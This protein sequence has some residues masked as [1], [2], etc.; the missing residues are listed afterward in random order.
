[1]RQPSLP[2]P[3]QDQASPLCPL[4]AHLH[5]RPGPFPPQPGGLSIERL[6]PELHQPPPLT[7]APPAPA[8]LPS[9]AAGIPASSRSSAVRAPASSS[10]ANPCINLELR[11]GHHLPRPTASASGR[12]GHRPA[13]TSFQAHHRSDPT[14]QGQM[15]WPRTH[16]RVWPT[17]SPGAPVTATLPLAPGFG[18]ACP[19]AQSSVGDLCW[20]AWRQR[21][22]LLC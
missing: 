13:S 20:W 8:F 11:Q 19:S 6:L 16:P 1:V 9:L 5:F 10:S 21:W 17:S 3:R 18:S 2:P 14:I 7:R 12:Y 4:S 15:I 22:T